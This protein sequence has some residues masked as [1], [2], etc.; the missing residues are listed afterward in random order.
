MLAYIKR[1][2]KKIDYVVLEDNPRHGIGY[3]FEWAIRHTTGDFI[4]ICGQDDIWLPEKVKLVIDVFVENS[5][6]EMVC[7]NLEDINANGQ[8]IGSRDSILLRNMPLSKMSASKVSRKDFLKLVVTSVMVAGP[9]VCVSKEFT[10]KC[11]PI[12]HQVTEDRW[13]QFC[14]VADDRMYYI[15]AILTRYRIHNSTTHSTGMKISDRIRKIR[16]RIQSYNT[17]IYQ[18]INY[19]ECARKYLIKWCDDNETAKEALLILD[20]VHNIGS[21]QLDASRSGRISGAIK[22]T[23]LFVT[24]VWYRRSGTGDY[25]VQLLNILL[26][27]KKKRRTEIEL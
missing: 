2:K 12:P 9:A 8:V 5:D 10:E 27:S 24:D 11:L 18:N 25:L 17:T 3:N 22:L 26:Y 7:H 6:A 20:I 16:R 23:R 1:C 14:A 13:T 15:N 21:R 4:F 19:S